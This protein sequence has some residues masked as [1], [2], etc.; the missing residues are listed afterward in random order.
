LSPDSYFSND[1]SFVK[2]HR[3][4][5]GILARERQENKRARLA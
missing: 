2:R 4:G 1:A 5:A 3:S